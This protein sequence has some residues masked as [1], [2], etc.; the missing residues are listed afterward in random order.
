[1]DRQIGTA[2]KMEAHHKGLLHRAVSVFIVNS[3]GEWILQKRAH[4]KY[5]SNGLWTN[6]CCTHPNPGE[7]VEDSAQRRLMEEMGIKCDLTKLFTFIYREKLDRELT[8]HELDHVFLGITDNLPVINTQE[9]EEWEAVSYN[10]LHDDIRKNPS[11][12]TFWF[13]EIYERVN[14]NI[15]KLRQG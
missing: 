10:D 2:G 4:D 1:N 9:V 12:Y 14:E 3:R 8:E 6:T 11:D 15:L 5:H 13:R 7:T